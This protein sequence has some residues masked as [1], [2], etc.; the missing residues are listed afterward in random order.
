[1]WEVSGSH[2]FVALP[3]CAQGL[4]QKT[5]VS[6]LKTLDFDKCNTEQFYTAFT[7]V[8]GLDHLDRDLYGLV[9]QRPFNHLLWQ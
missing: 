8:R 2:S 7:T 5:Y 6:K 9:K 1:M 4:L 3:A